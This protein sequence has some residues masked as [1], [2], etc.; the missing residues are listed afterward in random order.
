M[1]S[2]YSTNLK[3]ELIATGEQAGTWGGTTNTNL[4]TAL[5]EAVVGYGNPNFT[6]DA[7]LTL[8]LTN[9]NATQ[10]ARNLVLNVT[11]S[12]SL[13]ATRNLVVP[14]IEKPYVVQNNTT[15]GQ[16]IIVKTSGGSGVT[17]LNGASV[18]LYTDG[19]NVVPI[20]NTLVTTN[21][22]V[23]QVGTDLDFIYNGTTVF[24]ISSTGV[25]TALSNVVSNGTP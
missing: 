15:G 17:V 1:A 13:T 21:W 9:S 11:S 7:D 10:V 3:I 8:T 16:S 20:F 6:S 5:E 22:S 24:S 18:Y 4:G 19:T 14:T 23:R 12:G 2:N 25:I